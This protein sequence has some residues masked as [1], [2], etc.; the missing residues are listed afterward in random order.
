M[1]CVVIY[2]L[3]DK[4]SL[5][6]E[7]I[8]AYCCYIASCMSYAVLATAIMFD[9]RENY[10]LID[11]AIIPCPEVAAVML[12]ANSVCAYHADVMYCPLLYGFPFNRVHSTNKH[13]CR[14]WLCVDRIFATTTGLLFA[15]NWLKLTW[16]ECLGMTLLAFAAIIQ[17]V[18]SRVAAKRCNVREYIYYHTI[19]HFYLP[20]TFACWLY[21]RPLYVYLNHS[22]K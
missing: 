20:T 13:I 21:F 8:L 12:I 14:F 18:M 10:Q 1:H 19:W 11:N 17:L 3:S 4:A 2:Q 6:H 7:L 5:D 9:M 22:F 15:L 16:S